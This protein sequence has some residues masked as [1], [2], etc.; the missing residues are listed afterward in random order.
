MPSLDPMSIV[1][2]M[3][4]KSVWNPYDGT[5]SPTQNKVA[6]EV[7]VKHLHKLSVESSKEL[8][9]YKPTECIGEPRDPFP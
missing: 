3:P 1:H 7:P 4:F 8:T 5:V 6:H 2:P 9:N